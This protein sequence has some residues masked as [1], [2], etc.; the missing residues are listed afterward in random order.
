MQQLDLSLFYALHNLA[1][2]SALLDTAIIVCAEY[3]IYAVLLGVVAAF[4]LAWKK[5]EREHVMGY[6]L[7][8]VAALVARYGIASLIRHFWHRAR[9]FSALNIP[10]LVADSAYSFPS[11]HTIFMFALATVIL[12]FNKKFGWALMATGLLIGAARVAAGVHYPSD[13]LGGIVLGI[14]TGAAFV[15]LSKKIFR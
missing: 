6:C 4:A 8:L 2:Q 12:H 13:I 3:L 11:G 7:A 9:P 14:L 15:W 5:G 10:H 1:G